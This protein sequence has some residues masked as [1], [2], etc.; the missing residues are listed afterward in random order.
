MGRLIICIYS[1]SSVQRLV[2]FIKTVYA[3]DNAIPAIVKPIGAAAQI[4]VPEAHKI[5]Y[6]L[7][8][9]LI[10]L[11]ELKDLVD[12]LNVENIYFLT[13]SGE[14]IEPNDIPSDSDVAIVVHGSD[15]EFTKAELQ[16]GKSIKQKNVPAEL[17]PHISIAIL[18]YGLGK[19]V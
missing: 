13:Y 19:K 1:I 10:V 6:R 7:D 2:D 18:L 3:F 11:P 12:I 4:G 14:E 5:S 16:Y 9:P 15:G 17:P 8:K